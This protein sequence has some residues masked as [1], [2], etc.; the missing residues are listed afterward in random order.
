[1]GEYL[2]GITA[3]KVC[4]KKIAVG[5]ILGGSIG[6]SGTDQYI[7]VALYC[8]LSF[9]FVYPVLHHIMFISCVVITS[10]FV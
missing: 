1:M 10:L 3:Y 2:L 7:P 5:P 9:F 6:K 4:I 8:S